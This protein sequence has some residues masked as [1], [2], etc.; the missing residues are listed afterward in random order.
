[1]L[2]AGPDWETLAVNDLDDLCHAT[3]AL[4]DG[5]IYVRTRSALYAFARDSR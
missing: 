2:K 4:A 1:V 5:R 3:P